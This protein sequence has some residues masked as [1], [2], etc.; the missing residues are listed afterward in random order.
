M[1]SFPYR[2]EDSASASTARERGSAR[3]AIDLLGQA[4]TIAHDDR[5][6]E[7]TLAHIER[8]QRHSSLSW[9]DGAYW[10]FPE[11]MKIRTGP[12]QILT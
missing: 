2:L 1:C 10:P 12:K 7:V 4:A 9:F 11:S 8:A 5:A 6:D 3:Q